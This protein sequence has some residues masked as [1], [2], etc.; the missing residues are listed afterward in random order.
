MNLNLSIC[1]G[2]FFGPLAQGVL[3]A[4]TCCKRRKMDEVQICIHNRN[5]LHLAYRRFYQRTNT[6]IRWEQACLEQCLSKHVFF[7]DI[8]F[9]YLSNLSL[10]LIPELLCYW[11]LAFLICSQ[12]IL[13]LPYLQRRSLDH[14]ILHV[15]MLR[16]RFGIHLAG[17][18]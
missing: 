1:L 8:S 17:L 18:H 6:A 16:N 2:V 4:L 9:W 11:H 7:E 13:A 5:S 14:R 12:H 3:A 15:K 10:N